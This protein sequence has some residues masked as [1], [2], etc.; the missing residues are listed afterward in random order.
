MACKS[1]LPSFPP[2]FLLSLYL[3]IYLIYLFFLVKD[4][5]I[6]TLVDEDTSSLRISKSFLFKALAFRGL[7]K[8]QHEIFKWQTNK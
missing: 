3:S 1:F 6:T 2:P 8:K 5:T 7:F 4:F